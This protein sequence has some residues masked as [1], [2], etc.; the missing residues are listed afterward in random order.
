[1]PTLNF[2]VSSYLCGLWCVSETD[3]VLQAERSLSWNDPLAM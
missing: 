3:F 2:L 1:L